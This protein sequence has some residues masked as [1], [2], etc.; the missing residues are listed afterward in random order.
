MENDNRSNKLF[1][2]YLVNICIQ[3]RSFLD[4]YQIMIFRQLPNDVINRRHECRFNFKCHIIG[5]SSI[6]Y[7]CGLTMDEKVLLTTLCIYCASDTT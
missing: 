6:L 2:L 5:T 1:Y 7:L 3:I 4:N